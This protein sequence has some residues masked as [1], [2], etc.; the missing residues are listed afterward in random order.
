M[1]LLVKSLHKSQSGFTLIELLVALGIIGVL[2]AIFLPSFLSDTEAP[3]GSEEFVNS[4]DNIEN[5]K[6]ALSGK[7]PTDD[8][9]ER[10]NGYIAEAE[11]AFHT[12]QTSGKSSGIVLTSSKEKLEKL[13]KWIKTA[14][15]Q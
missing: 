6:S 3:P 9:C 8:Q 1:R 12:M 5:M 15:P 2:A 10:L 11:N 7:N 4:T 13:T 14:C